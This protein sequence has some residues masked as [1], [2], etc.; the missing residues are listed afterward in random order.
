MNYL[1]TFLL[2]KWLSDKV[3]EWEAGSKSG[4][5]MLVGERKAAVVDGVVLGHVTKAKGARRA[6]VVN[7]SALLAWVAANHP[8]EVETITRVNPAFV[9]KLLTQ[10]KTRGAMLD[11]DGV[12]IDGLIEVFDSAPTLQ[13]KLTPEADSAIAGLLARGAVGVSGLKALAPVIDAEIVE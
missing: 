4:I 12:V 11:D 7:E 10:A 1:A 3:T 6:K 9:D 13:R 2:A 5:E 8:T